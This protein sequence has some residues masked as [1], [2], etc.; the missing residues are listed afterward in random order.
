MADTVPALLPPL[1]NGLVI[2]LGPIGGGVST[3]LPPKLEYGARVV[4][5]WNWGS[6]CCCLRAARPEDMS[7]VLIKEELCANVAARLEISSRAGGGK[8]LVSASLVVGGV[9]RVL[10]TEDW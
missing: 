10:A 7:W 5:R 8:G 6:G 2:S 3:L 4:L 1:L 9:G